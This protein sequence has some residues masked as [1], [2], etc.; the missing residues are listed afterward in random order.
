MNRPRPNLAELLRDAARKAEEERDFNAQVARVAAI[1][2]PEI[3][4]LL[5]RHKAETSNAPSDYKLTCAQCGAVHR[6]SA[7]DLEPWETDEETTDTGG[8]SDVDPDDDD[9]DNRQARSNNRKPIRPLSGL[10]RAQIVASLNKI[11]C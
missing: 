8:D 9:Y 7:E 3:D 4:K 2:K 6:I 10:T 1:A 5:A 11:R